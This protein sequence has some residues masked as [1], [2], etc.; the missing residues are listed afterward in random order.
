[1]IKGLHRLAVEEEGIRAGVEE[2]AIPVVA[3]V[4]GEEEGVATLVEEVVEII[5]QIVKVVE[6]EVEVEDDQIMP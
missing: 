1:M 6:M 5:I 2:G 3:G 4:V